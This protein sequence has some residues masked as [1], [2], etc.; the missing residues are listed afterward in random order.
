MRLE[1][2]LTASGI[3][4]PGRAQAWPNRA[5][6]RLREGPGKAQ[7]K[8]TQ[9]PSKAQARPRQSPDKA[10][11]RPPAR[12]LARAGRKCNREPVFV[13]WG[14][15]LQVANVIVGLAWA[16]PRPG[17]ALCLALPGPCL[18]SAW[19]LPGYCLGIT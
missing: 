13:F 12:A 11:T 9:C 2:F 15:G 3:P 10:Q 5:R 14:A 19:A 4:S 1:R 8:P 7:A 16:R 17:L 18:G 6:A